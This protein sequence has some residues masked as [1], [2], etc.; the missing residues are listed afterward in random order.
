M[1]F[2]LL[3]QAAPDELILIN[4]DRAIP[5][6]ERVHKSCVCFIVIAHF[7]CPLSYC[8]IK[9]ALIVAVRLLECDTGLAM[10]SQDEEKA[11]AA[12]FLAT[13]MTYISIGIT[14]ILANKI[15]NFVITLT[16]ISIKTDKTAA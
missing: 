1:L 5:L 4:A 9:S 14:T 6:I 12:T 2:L 13:T 11:D 8:R 15:P 16:K 7:V 10:T 3:N